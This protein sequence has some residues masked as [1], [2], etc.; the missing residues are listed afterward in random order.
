MVKPDG[1]PPIEEWMGYVFTAFLTPSLILAWLSNANGYLPTHR[2]LVD[3]STQ[4]KHTAS[5]EQT[6]QT[7]ST[8]SARRSSFFEPRHL[9]RSSNSGMSCYH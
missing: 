9:S 4:K 8:A 7:E 3:A 1:L 6:N 2:P 5:K